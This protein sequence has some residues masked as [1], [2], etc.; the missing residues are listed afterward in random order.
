MWCAVGYRP[1]VYFSSCVMYDI[2]V[3]KNSFY[4]RINTLLFSADV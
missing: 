3:N 2:T 4:S 1:S